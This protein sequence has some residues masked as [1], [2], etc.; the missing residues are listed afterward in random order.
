MQIVLL[1][2]V[3]FN[4]EYPGPRRPGLIFVFSDN[5]SWR[6]IDGITVAGSAGTHSGKHTFLRFAQAN[7]GVLAQNISVVEYE[8]TFVL[9]AVSYNG[10]HLD[11]GQ[12]TARGVWYRDLA[13]NPTD[14]QGQQLNERRY[15]V[16]GGTGPYRDVRGQGFESGNGLTKTL[17][18]DL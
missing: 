12:V 15:A 7:D 2:T 16:T 13:G 10:N 6:S 3:K 11:A 5:L 18:I 1:A 9:N 4:G 8:A 14:A 17:Q